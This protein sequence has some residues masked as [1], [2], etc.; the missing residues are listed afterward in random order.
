MAALGG[1]WSGLALRAHTPLRSVPA[2][3]IF[4]GG[5]NPAHPKHI[6]SIDPNCDVVEVVKGHEG[7]PGTCTCTWSAAT[8]QPYFQWFLKRLLPHI[9]DAYETSRMLCEQYYLTS[10]DIEITQVNCARP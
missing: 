2:A 3:L 9:A 4:D 8:Y 10:P 6:G 1:R 5:V 7:A